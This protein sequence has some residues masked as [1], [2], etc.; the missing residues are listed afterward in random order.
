MPTRADEFEHRLRR[1]AQ[2]LRRVA[3]GEALSAVCG[4]K[5]EPALR[6]VERWAARDEGF[7]HALGEAKRAGEWL[8]RFAFKDDEAAAFLR[9]LGTERMTELAKDR[10]LPRGARLAYWRASQ[11]QFGGDVRA[12]IEAKRSLRTAGLVRSKLWAWDRATADRVLIW[13]GRGTPLPRMAEAEAGLP[14][15][16]VISRWRRE[17]AEFDLE[18]R[19]MVRVG[20]RRRAMARTAALGEVGLAVGERLLDGGSLNSLAGT[21][22]LPCAKTLYAWM[23]RSPEF[24]RHIE[25]AY[26]M[27]GMFQDEGPPARGGRRLGW[28]RGRRGGG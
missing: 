23:K 2:V 18:V 8:R 24:A 28:G 15:L 22:G 16:K 19:W 12:V 5:D 17:V 11:V 26:D 3:A 20:R 9:R 13:L 1:R 4:G 27:R 10:T 6:T 7:A 25:L 21:G 14:G